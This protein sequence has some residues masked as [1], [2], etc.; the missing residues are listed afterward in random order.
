MLIPLKVKCL[1]SSVQALEN[2]TINTFDSYNL[3]YRKI[4]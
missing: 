2:P 1:A 4:K 3:Q